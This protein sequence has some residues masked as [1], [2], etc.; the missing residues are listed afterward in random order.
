MKK[1][2]ILV[3]L[4]SSFGFSETG[5]Q[6]GIA[7]MKEAIA[8][9]I[10]ETRNLSAKV[11]KRHVIYEKVPLEKSYLDPYIADFVKRNRNAL[12]VNNQY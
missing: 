7:D 12:P 11:D 6:V 5:N 10:V 8:R 2:L 3:F 4:L 1:Y 9:L